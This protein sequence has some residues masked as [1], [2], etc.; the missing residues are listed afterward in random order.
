MSLLG[1]LVRSLL[2]FQDVILPSTVAVCC[3]TSPTKL[4]N[5]GVE[6]NSRKAAEFAYSPLFEIPHFWC[7]CGNSK[8]FS[9]R[10]HSLCFE[11]PCMPAPAGVTVNLHEFILHVC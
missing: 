1:I 2:S 6:N 11:H 10:Q 9:Y 3:S 5:L 8:H 7:F 4:E